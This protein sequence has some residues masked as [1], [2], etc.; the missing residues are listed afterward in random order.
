ME[1]PLVGGDLD[2]LWVFVFFRR[3]EIEIVCKISPFCKCGNA[4]N[5]TE[6]NAKTDY[7]NTHRARW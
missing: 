2:R 6:Q 5:D 4:F 1:T 7:S 3:S